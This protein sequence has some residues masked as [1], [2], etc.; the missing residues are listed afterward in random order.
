MEKNTL[1]KQNYNFG[2]RIEII[3]IILAGD[4]NDDHLCGGLKGRTEHISW[5]Q[6]KFNNKIIKKS[7]KNTNK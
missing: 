3:I 2:S 5:T 7:P 6:S 1:K 4:H